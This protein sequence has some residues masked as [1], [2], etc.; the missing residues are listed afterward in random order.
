MRLDLAIVQDVGKRS[1]QQDSATAHGLPAGNGVMLV[2]ADGL[3]GHTGGATASRLAIESFA[4]ATQDA[5]FDA[6]VQRRAALLETVHG[7][8][9][10]ISDAARSIPANET[11]GTTLVSAIVADGA[12]RWISVG[13]SHLYHWRGGQLAKLNAD[14]S[15]AGLMVASGRFKPDDAELNPYRSL[16]RSA[17]TGRNIELIDDPEGEVAIAPGD[18]IVLSSDGLNTIENSEIEKIVTRGRGEGAELLAARLIDAVKSRGLANQDN[19]SVVVA[20]IDAIDDDFAAP[21]TVPRTPTA[22]AVQPTAIAAAPVTA[23]TV[24]ERIEAQSPKPVEAAA[25]RRPPKPLT[26]PAIALPAAQKSSSLVGPLIGVV[27]LAALAGAGYL[28]YQQFAAAPPTAAT[29]PPKAQPPAPAQQPTTPTRAAPP[30]VAA[31]PQPQQVPQAAPVPAAPAPTSPAPQQQSVPQPSAPPAPVQQQSS[32]PSPVLTPAAPP[33]GTASPPVGAPQPPRPAIQDQGRTG[34]PAQGSTGPQPTT[35]PQVTAP[36]AGG[37]PGLPRGTAS[38]PV[39]PAPRP[40]LTEEPRPALRPALP[41][42]EP[43][44]TVPPPTV[45][46]PQVPRVPA[47]RPGFNQGSSGEAPRQP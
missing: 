30:P 36:G 16:L 42:N 38:P 8:N 22:E 18:V 32:P 26:A 43:A 20:C 7:A 9:G 17:L 47:P 37:Q 31:P 3:G 46:P 25:V 6:H 13:D 41:P 33:A 28:A 39:G 23:V 11:M 34:P 27:G 12:V 15:Q 21:P 14:H 19:T 5:R 10:R 40:Q 29:S 44:Q 1:E 24:T 45:E 35:A 4:E 2:V